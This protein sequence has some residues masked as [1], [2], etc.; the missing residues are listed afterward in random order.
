MIKSSGLLGSK[1]YEI[2]ETWTGQCKLEHA[3]YAL[4][5]LLKGLKVFCPVSPL[6]VPKGHG[7][8]QYPPS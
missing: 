8:N 2:Q 6:R 7:L 1:T 5:S 3:N 4:K